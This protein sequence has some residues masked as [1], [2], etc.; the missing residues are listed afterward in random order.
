MLSDKL[1]NYT[2]LVGMTIVDA[3]MID[4]GEYCND[5][6]PCLLVQDKEGNKYELL[7]S[8]DSEQNG[9]GVIECTKIEQEES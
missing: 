1:K 3:Y 7:V 5:L 6:F 2:F 4:F 8:R 9:P